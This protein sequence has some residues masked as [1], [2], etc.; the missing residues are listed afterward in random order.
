MKLK[1][2]YRIIERPAYFRKDL[3]LENQ[4]SY[5]LY[6]SK[7]FFIKYYAYLPLVYSLKNVLFS[8][9]S[10]ILDIGCADGPF[11]PTLNY[12]ARSIVANDINEEYIM[13]SKNLIDN[14]LKKSKKINLACS[15]GQALPFRESKFD[16]IFCLEVL[17]HVKNPDRFIKE[18]F[19]VLRK[20]GTLIC[21]LPVEIGFSLLIRTFIGKIVN[22][23]RPDYSLK[24]LIQNVLLKRPE[25]RPEYIG[26][27]EYG[28]ETGHKNFDW[29]VI[30][31]KIKL[32]F[33]I[34]GI[35]FIPINFLKDINPIV[36]I[37]A[38]KNN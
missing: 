1:K 3:T 7:S 37:K 34:V 14:K 33:K 9:H 13:E 15:D 16:L 24:Q 30:K 22:F 28:G 8:E 23:K 11:L 25:A 31:Q 36:L 21:T 27:R 26:H 32:Y 10:R 5:Y 4:Y 35:K 20:H 18:I 2:K 17:E 12:Y 38:I 29:R 19:R 6:N